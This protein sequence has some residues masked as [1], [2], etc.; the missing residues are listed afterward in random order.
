MKDL[1]RWLVNF[2]AG[3]LTPVTTAIVTLAGVALSFGWI[4]QETYQLIATVGS[5]GI[6]AGLAR[7]PFQ[8]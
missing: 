7:K 6:G 5:V 1:L 2:R 3:Q 8:D 4:D